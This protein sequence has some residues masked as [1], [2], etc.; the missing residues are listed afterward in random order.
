MGE[1][2]IRGPHI[3]KGYFANEKAT[4]ETIDR[5]GWLHSGDIGYYDDDGDFFIVDRAKELI[6]YKSFQVLERNLGKT[7]FNSKTT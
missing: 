2:C 3:M 6:K 4:A 1:I 7:Q 5:D